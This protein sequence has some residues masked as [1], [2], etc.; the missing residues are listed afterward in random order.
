[1][2]DDLKLKLLGHVP[3]LDEQTKAY[4]RG[5]ITPASPRG[6]R[7]GKFDYFQ[8]GFVDLRIPRD[9]AYT[10]DIRASMQRSG[11]FAIADQKGR[12]VEG[13]LFDSLRDAEK[14]IAGAKITFNVDVKVPSSDA[15][16]SD[17]TVPAR[18]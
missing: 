6:A 5:P 15:F 2:S 1:M 16:K 17:V 7:E 12:L 3:D 9:S 18:A 14:G 13:A 11:K 8:A 10:E 4:C